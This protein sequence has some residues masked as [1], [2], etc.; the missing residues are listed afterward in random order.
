[1]GDSIKL[2]NSIL[3]QAEERIHEFEDKTIQVIESEEQKR[4]KNILQINKTSDIWGTPS[5]TPTYVY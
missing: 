2:F 1:M 3:E 4:Q 5:G